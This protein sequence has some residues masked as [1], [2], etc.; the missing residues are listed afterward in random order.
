MKV[1]LSSANNGTWIDDCDSDGK[2]YN[3]VKYYLN[4]SIFPVIWAARELNSAY[5]MLQC[6]PEES[7]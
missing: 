6:C 5:N 2:R 4:S 7:A 1:V 3:A